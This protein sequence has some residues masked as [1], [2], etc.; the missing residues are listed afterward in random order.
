M[1]LKKKETSSSILPFKGTYMACVNFQTK[2][3]SIT[4]SLAIRNF[5]HEEYQSLFNK[6]VPDNIFYIL[7]KL[8][9]KYTLIRQDYLNMKKEIPKKLQQNIEAALVFDIKKFTPSARELINLILNNKKCDNVMSKLSNKNGAKK[10][11]IV[12]KLE[13]RALAVRKMKS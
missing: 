3:R 2:L 5:L 12:S 13:K 9:I 6:K 1:K 7:I 11:T 10:S 4:K 8:K